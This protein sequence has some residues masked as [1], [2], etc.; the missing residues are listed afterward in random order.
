MQTKGMK[1]YFETRS[2]SEV[3]RRDFP[4]LQLMICNKWNPAIVSLGELKSDTGDH[5]PMMR[6]SEMK[7]STTSNNYEY[8]DSIDDASLLHSVEPSLSNLKEQLLEKVSR[9]VVEVTRYD[10][11]LEDFPTSQ[12]YMSTERHRKISAEVLADR[13]GIGIE[14]ARAT[15]RAT[16][17]R[18]TWS[19]IP[20]ISRQYRA[21]RQH[22]VKRLNGK[23]ATDMIR[24]KS[25]FLRGKLASRMYRHKC[26]FNVSYPIPR[27]NSEH[28]GYI[29]NDFVS[30]YGAHDHLTYNGAAVQ[31]GSN[32]N[33]QNSVQKYKIKTHVS[34]P[35]RPR[36]IGILAVNS[37]RYSNGQHR[38][39]LSGEKHLTYP[40]IWILVFTIE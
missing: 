26:R 36:E 39:R 31:V 1:I 4:K 16:V 24:E 13:F 21:Y 27:A 11:V 7:V 17:Q 23:F 15:L 28:V 25:M 2:P 10:D 6:I 8:L 12:T 22:T 37:S 34:A 14:R 38:L 29:L 32:T 19:A 5:M 3:E 35:W 18:G 20:P 30:D 9:N 40:S 33:F